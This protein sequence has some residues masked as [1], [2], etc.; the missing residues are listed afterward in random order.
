[1]VLSGSWV[2]RCVCVRGASAGGSPVGRD[3]CEDRLACAQST[4]AAVLGRLRR[5][6]AP[7]RSLGAASGRDLLGAKAD[8]SATR[9]RHRFGPRKA[10]CGFLWVRAQCCRLGYVGGCLGT[11]YTPSN[12]RTSLGEAHRTGDADP[13]FFGRT[14]PSSHAVQSA[15]QS[16]A[17]PKKVGVPY[18]GGAREG[19]EWSALTV[20]H[21][22]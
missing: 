12:S 18:S 17:A 15:T 6:R 22:L 16:T 7:L 2:S 5:A 11:Q 21:V 19:G 13:R 4:R 20:I 10:R 14:D 1:M 3:P 8:G 9:P